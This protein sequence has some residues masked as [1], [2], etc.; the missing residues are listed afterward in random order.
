MAKAK[1]ALAKGKYAEADQA[2][3]SAVT[4]SKIVLGEEHA[5]YFKALLLVIEIKTLL[6]SFEECNHL[7]SSLLQFWTDKDQIT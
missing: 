1:D 2:L 4:S 7:L 3:E 5:V 6:A